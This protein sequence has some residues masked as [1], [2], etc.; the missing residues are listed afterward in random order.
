MDPEEPHSWASVRTA[1]GGDQS[2]IERSVD[3]QMSSREDT[4]AGSDSECEPAE[5]NDRC[6]DEKATGEI[7]R[8]A[9]SS[10]DSTAT[11]LPNDAIQ[12]DGKIERDSN[13][14][15]R[16]KRQVSGTRKFFYICKYRKC[17]FRIV[18]ADILIISRDT[19]FSRIMRNS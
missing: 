10:N 14:A 7:D 13:N 12:D 17:R 1:S 11:K 2:R 15:K 4:S 8:A 18:I 3:G 9:A 6:I 19:L 5:S 16:G